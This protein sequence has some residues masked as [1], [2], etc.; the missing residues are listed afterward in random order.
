VGALIL[1]EST[2]IHAEGMSS[3]AF[4]H[5]PMEMLDRD[6]ATLVFTGE[7]RT[8]Q[9]NQRLAQELAAS[10]QRCYE[11][12]PGAALAPFRLLESEPLLQPV[13]EILPVQMMT[14]ALAGLAGREA[15]RF[16]RASKVTTT[17]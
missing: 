15:G 14:L 3:A 5:G 7:E 17:E 1:K 11:I 4:R 9:L 16:E 10:G 2:R 6:M 12:G 8:R 13:L